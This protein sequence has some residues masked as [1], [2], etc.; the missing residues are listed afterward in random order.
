MVIIGGKEISFTGSILYPNLKRKTFE[1]LESFGTTMLDSDPNFDS[2]LPCVF[3]KASDGK[4]YLSIEKE[5]D[6][7]FTPNQGGVHADALIGAITV[8]GDQPNL[9]I[10]GQDGNLWGSSWN[11]DTDQA[12]WANHGLPGAGAVG[13]EQAMGAVAANGDRPYVFIKGS[14]GNLWSR[15]QTNS[16]GD[17]GWTVHGTPVPG[18]VGIDKAMGAIIVDEGR[19]YVFLTG[20]DGNLWS[21]WWNDDQKNW[22]WSNE[23]TPVPGE[24]AIALAMGAISLN[25]RRP[26]IFVKGSD[27]NL[28]SRWWALP[29]KQWAWTNH[30]TPPGIQTTASVGSVATVKGEVQ[31]YLKGDDGHLWVRRWTD[32]DKNWT[33]NSFQT[34]SDVSLEYPFGVVSGHLG[35]A[36]AFFKGNDGNLWEHRLDGSATEWINKGK[37]IGFDI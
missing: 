4:L 33:W 25:G 15:N 7:E 10:K 18:E 36:Y 32:Q 17:W 23:G 2:H 16:G 13:I 24:V 21:R 26:Y 1:I 6:P 28:W 30:G 29:E 20:S 22:V 5:W 8:N 19:P 11:I 27:G 34:P 35:R 9:F 37:P 31:V 12:A 3:V 14:D